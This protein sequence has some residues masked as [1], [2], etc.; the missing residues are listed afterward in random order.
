[1]PEEQRVIIMRG[2]PGS[3]KTTYWKELYPDAVC[4]SANDY[5]TDAD[6]KYR[7]DRRQ[8]KESHRYC[9]KVFMQ[10]IEDGELLI[11]VDNT[12]IK[13]WELEG[14]VRKAEENCYLVTVYRMIVDD[15]REAASR[16]IHDVPAEAVE[17]MHAGMEDYP[18]EIMSTL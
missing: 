8:L 15:W 16:N 3:G 17:R 5:F 1:M 13:C 12:N 14:Y 6:G 18:D 10:A 11:V 4:C 7:Y 9:Q 2:I